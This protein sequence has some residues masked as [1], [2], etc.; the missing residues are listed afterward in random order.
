MTETELTALTDE[1]LRNSALISGYDPPVNGDDEVYAMHRMLIRYVLSCTTG[2][3]TN[4]IVINMALCNDRPEAR[5]RKGIRAGEVDLL[6]RARYVRWLFA[7]WWRG[8]ET[9]LPA[10]REQ[11]VEV[12]EKYCWDQHDY[13]TSLEPFASANGR[14]AR[15]VYYMLT[16]A[17]KNPVRIIPASK[18]AAYNENHRSYREKVFAP[19]MRAHG[20][21]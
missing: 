10:M 3:L 1:A 2:A 7:I 4:P 19:L 15:I 11:P 14:T 6:P 8:V 13:L 5:F 9:K 17:L 16:T 12:R 21:I 20:Y 18:A